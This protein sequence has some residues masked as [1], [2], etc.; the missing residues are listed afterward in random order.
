[1]FDR[2]T[3]C[4]GTLLTSRGLG[5]LIALLPLVANSCECFFQFGHHFLHHF[6]DLMFHSIPIRVTYMPGRALCITF[7]AF[8][9]AAGRSLRLLSY[10]VPALFPLPQHT[11]S[12]APLPLQ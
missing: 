4:F 10:I 1:M 12:S 5:F 8:S 7:G 3:L 9:G 2:Y 11:R 6:L